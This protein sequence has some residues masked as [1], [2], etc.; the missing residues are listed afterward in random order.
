M[1]LLT[2][3]PIDLA[4]LIAAVGDDAHGAI[5]TFSGTTRETSPGDPRP[6]AALDYEAYAEMAL[7]D[8]RAIAEEARTRFGPLKIAIV[9]RTGS[10]PLGEVSV[11]VAVGT[12]HRA[13]SF[14][15]CEF[16][17]DT[18]KARSPIWKRERYRDGGTAWIANAEAGT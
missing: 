16:A 15:A 9:H 18:L 1:L 6:V 12:P 2:N 8:F 11:A 4:A 7:A 10:V 17:I 3:E 14:D 5:C 13:A